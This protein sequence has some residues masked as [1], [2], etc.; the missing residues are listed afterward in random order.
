MNNTTIVI[1]VAFLLLIVILILFRNKSEYFT[2]DPANPNLI[3]TRNGELQKRWALM[4]PVTKKYTGISVWVP[5]QPFPQ[6][7]PTNVDEWN[8]YYYLMNKLD[9]YLYANFDDADLAQA[10]IDNKMQKL[11]LEWKYY[12]LPNVSLVTPVSSILLPPDPMPVLNTP[13]S[14]T[15]MQVPNTIPG[16]PLTQLPQL[17]P[18]STV[19]SFPVISTPPVVPG[20]FN[21]QTYAPTYT[22][23]YG[24]TIPTISPAIAPQFTT[25]YSSDTVP[26][27]AAPLAPVSATPY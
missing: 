13:V 20:T 4:D 17:P 19:P 22:S 14:P 8:K 25:N 16:Q 21:A 23:T 3:R 27:L 11:R 1:L 2:P 5:V 24:P 9:G 18:V 7:D 10:Y 26:A 12:V 6:P 15:P